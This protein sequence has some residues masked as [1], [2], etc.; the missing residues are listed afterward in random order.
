MHVYVCVLRLLFIR[1]LRGI[2]FING[3]WQSYDPLVV[4]SF[5]NGIMQHSWTAENRRACNPFTPACT[6]RYLKCCCVHIVEN[7]SSNDKK[8]PME[9]TGKYLDSNINPPRRIT[10]VTRIESKNHRYS[11]STSKQSVE[12]SETRSNLTLRS[13][14]CLCSRS[15]FEPR[16]IPRDTNSRNVREGGRGKK[17]VTLGSKQTVCVNVLTEFGWWKMAWHRLVCAAR[18]QKPFQRTTMLAKLLRYAC[19]PSPPRLV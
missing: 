18:P 12:T 4:C 3:A 1:G 14:C 19:M 9:K 8:F 15:A 16:C 17:A 7:I 10:L 13:R 6:S 2:K 11:F 5:D